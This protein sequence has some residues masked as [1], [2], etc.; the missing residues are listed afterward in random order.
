M[1]EAPTVVDR[2]TVI[3]ELN[4]LINL[5]YDAIAAYEAAI[6]RLNNAEYRERL[7]EFK[8]DHQRHTRKL[9][10]CVRRF[11]GKTV[12]SGDI[13]KV[14]AKGKVILGNIN[15]DKGVLEAM[16]SNE[17]QT[18]RL[19]EEALQKLG[20]EPEVAGILLRNLEDERRHRLWLVSTLDEIVT[21]SID[22]P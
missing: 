19:Y 18:N 7:R 17:N 20:D 16:K 4:K 15:H 6:E 9:E 2:S 10:E 5:D 8:G 21:M 12:T 1:A 22:A 3:N 14:L 11:G 13:R